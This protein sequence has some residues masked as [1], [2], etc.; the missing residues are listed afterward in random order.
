MI[1]AT[2]EAID[3]SILR[4]TT[5]HGRDGHL[6]EAIPIDKLQEVMKKY[7]RSTP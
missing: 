2:E 1:E 4:A 5:V 7:G 3:N 6:A